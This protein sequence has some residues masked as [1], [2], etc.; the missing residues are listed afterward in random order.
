MLG[1][2]HGEVDEGSQKDCT[3]WF[4]RRRLRR[5]PKRYI[6]CT[7]S[8]RCH[9]CVRVGDRHDGRFHGT[10]TPIPMTQASLFGGILARAQ[11]AHLG[12]V[13]PSTLSGC[14]FLMHTRTNKWYLRKDC[15][16]LLCTYMFM[17]CTRSL[18]CED[19]S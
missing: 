13:L 2:N 8:A 14:T 7:C 18:G 4:E 1:N 19:Y 16:I 11:R 6:P 15:G 5:S 9:H 17:S 3:V 10:A 12:S